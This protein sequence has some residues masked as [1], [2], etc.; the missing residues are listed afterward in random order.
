MTISSNEEWNHDKLQHAI[1]RMQLIIDSM[2]NLKDAVIVA[3]ISAF[4][5]AIDF[6]EYNMEQSEITGGNGD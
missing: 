3:E 4:Q 1:Y 2:K 5:H 6:I